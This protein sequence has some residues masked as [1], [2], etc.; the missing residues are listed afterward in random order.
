MAGHSQF[1]NIMFRKGA[2]D[3]K[4]SKIFS[5]LGREITVAAK[6][7]LPDPEKNAKLRAA[8]IAARKENMPKDSI[9]RAIKKAQGADAAN[10]EDVRYEGRGPGGISLIVEALTDN[11]NRTGSDVRALFSKFG[12]QMGE[13]VAYMFDRLGQV[14]FPA[15][16]ANA[17]AMLDAAIEAGADDC[18]STNQVHDLYCVPDNLN[19]VREALEKRFGPATGAKLVWRPQTTVPVEG[20]AAETLL[21]L[22]DA[23]EDHDDVQNVFANFEMSEA[24]MAKLTA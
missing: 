22:L 15:A 4:R 10:Y 18:Q 9:E 14:Q 5:K 3:A 13:T 12:G 20:D 7:G 1:K 24:T 11:R 17:D 2:Q 16:K 8:I 19:E 23:L 6:A 21:K